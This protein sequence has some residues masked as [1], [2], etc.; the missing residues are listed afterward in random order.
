MKHARILADNKDFNNAKDKLDEA[1][2][3]LERNELDQSDPLIVG[4][5]SEVKQFK[6]LME[7][8]DIYDKLGRAFAFASEL[9][10]ALQ[11]ASARGDVSELRLFATKA[12][13][14][15]VDQAIKYEEN[16]TEYKVPTAA[17][18]LKQRIVE[19]KEEEKK[20][21]KVFAGYC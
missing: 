6:E 1:K 18:D 11:R 8:P 4:L 21:K 7:T 9:S 14:Q 15:T 13:N 12:M 5:L 3:D 19:Q 20:N 16:P 17:D 10:H 2:K